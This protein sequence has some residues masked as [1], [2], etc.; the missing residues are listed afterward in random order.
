MCGIAGYIKN[1][2]SSQKEFEKIILRMLTVSNHR[3][4]DDCKYII[5]KIIH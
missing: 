5:G 1:L 2:K 4:P 3:G